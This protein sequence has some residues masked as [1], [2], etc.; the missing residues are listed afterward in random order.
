MSQEGGLNC[1]FANFSW[2]L[3][4]FEVLLKITFVFKE[5]R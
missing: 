1:D 4:L 5:L 3:N 2:N